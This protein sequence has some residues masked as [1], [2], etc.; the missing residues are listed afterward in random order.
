MAVGAAHVALS[1]LGFDFV[2]AAAVGDHAA[3]C[4]V[5][6][7]R[8]AVIKFEYADVVFAAVNAGVFKQV[9]PDPHAGADLAVEILCPLSA[10]ARRQRGLGH[11]KQR[12]LG[13]SRLSCRSSVGGHRPSA[14][15]PGLYNRANAGL[16]GNRVLPDPGIIALRLLPQSWRLGL[17][18]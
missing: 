1:D 4:A 18:A 15:K 8:V 5:L 6:L 14:Q 11:G 10:H 9:A 7:L 17:A 2:D 16:R 13:Y 12:G 3:Y